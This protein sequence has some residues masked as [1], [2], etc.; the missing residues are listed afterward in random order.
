MSV[1]KSY[2]P[3]HTQIYICTQIFICTRVSAHMYIHV[4]MHAHV[5]LHITLHSYRL[6]KTIS[7]SS[8]QG[9]GANLNSWKHINNRLIGRISYMDTTSWVRATHRATQECLFTMA[10]LNGLF[11]SLNANNFIYLCRK[12]FTFAEIQIN[13]FAYSLSA[14]PCVLGQDHWLLYSAQT[15]SSSSAAQGAA[16][17]GSVRAP[18]MLRQKKCKAEKPRKIWVYRTKAHVCWVQAVLFLN[19]KK[20]E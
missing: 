5:Y 8:N 4:H 2:F 18:S 10:F 12:V 19:P 9:K 17:P 14:L 6:I 3:V 11:L 15:N 20:E 16:F 7:D 13:V 1:R